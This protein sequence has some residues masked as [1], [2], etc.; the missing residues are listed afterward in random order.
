MPD[1]LTVQ[2]SAEYSGYSVRTIRQKIRDGELP[3]YRPRGGRA[4]RIDRADLDT[5]IT[6][7]ATAP[8]EDEDPEVAALVAGIQA[9]LDDHG[10]QLPDLTEE[11]VRL[12]ARLMPPPRRSS[13]GGEPDAA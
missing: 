9:V 1:W 4:L 6:G 11:Q 8:N 10:D 13:G 7:T 12:F 2:G 5:M 3:A